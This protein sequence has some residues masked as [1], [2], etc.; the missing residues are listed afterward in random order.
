MSTCWSRSGSPW[1]EPPLVPASIWRN[2]ASTD[3]IASDRPDLLE[4]IKPALANVDYFTPG[5]DEALM[6]CGLY[7]RHDV[8]QFFLD[9]GVKHTVFK[10][11]V[12]GSNIVLRGTNGAVEEIRVPAFGSPVV[13]STGCGVAYC[14]GFIAGL[15]HGWDLVE[16]AR[17]GT[18]AASLVIRGLGSD[19]GIADFD[20][21]V[22]FMR[23]AETLPITN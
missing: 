12:E 5:L 13:D 7:E 15:L 23:S 3:L 14:A 17:F 6:I 16:C 19:A 18:A 4:V 9:R 8:I 21:T 1:P 10:M 22:K 2:L 20:H 11:G